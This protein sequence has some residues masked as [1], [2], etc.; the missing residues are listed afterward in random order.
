MDILLTT[1]QT[2][3]LDDLSAIEI[4]HPKIDYNLGNE[5]NIKE[6]NESLDL[7]DAINNNYVVLT[8]NGTIITDVSKIEETYAN[9]PEEINFNAYPSINQNFQTET[10]LNFDT[11]RET[12]GFI[13][14]ASGELV[15][16]K[17]GIYFVIVVVSAGVVSGTD[18][19]ESTHKLQHDVGGVGSYVDVGIC[20]VY[21]RAINTGEG[22]SSIMI[23]LNLQENDK[24]RVVSERTV[25]S[26]SLQTIGLGSSISLFSTKAIG[27]KASTIQP[28]VSTT[29]NT[30]LLI[31]TTNDIT[32]RG[33]YFDENLEAYLGDEVTVNNIT[34]ISPQ[35][36][37]INCTTN[38]NAQTQTNLI[39][40]RNGESHFGESP[41]IEVS[42]TLVGTGVSGTF[43]TNFNSGGTGNTLWGADWDLEIFGAINSLDGYFASSN[44]G[45]SSSDTGPNAALDG[46]NYAFVETSM[47][48]NGVG[49]Y[50]QVTTTNFHEI[51]L[52]DFY[53][54]MHGSNTGALVMLSQNGDNSWTERW[55]QDGQFQ[56]DGASAWER[57]TIYANTWNAKAIRFVFEAA[58][59]YMGDICID[60]LAI[61]SI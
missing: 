5:F 15:V 42:T 11:I 57:A 28:Y 23:A 37:I 32:I 30:L 31:N 6:I 2:V 36:I 16:T 59:G 43:I 9:L 19:S 38:S 25:G 56:A 58:S 52:I 49:N 39:I 46:T 45:T 22:S 26:S 8:V 40:S 13:N 50:G 34:F 10:V 20:Y 51:S 55:R 14:L 1:N 18:R 29:G 7:Q 4:I 60:N 35:E 12:T 27:G 24:L 41:T 61:T 17:A 3:I 54:Y 44:A 21:H 33:D 48:N 53:Y 47:P